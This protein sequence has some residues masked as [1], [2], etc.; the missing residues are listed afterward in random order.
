MKIRRQDLISPN[1]GN[2]ERMS[3]VNLS[4]P[5]LWKRIVWQTLSKEPLMISLA[6]DSCKSGCGYTSEMYFNLARLL[7]S[8]GAFKE[9]E[10]VDVCKVEVVFDCLTESTAVALL[11]ME[12]DVN[13]RQ[14]L[15]L[16]WLSEIKRTVDLRNSSDSPVL[17]GIFKQS[18]Q[19]FTLDAQLLFEFKQV[20][21]PWNE[22]V[23]DEDL[24]GLVVLQTTV[25]GLQD[26][27]LS[28]QPRQPDILNNV[29]KNIAHDLTGD[30]ELGVEGSVGVVLVP[31]WVQVGDNGRQSDGTVF[32][33][34]GRWVLGFKLVDTV[35]VGVDGLDEVL[36]DLHVEQVQDGF[37][38]DRG[39]LSDDLLTEMLVD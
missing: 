16:K 30:G 31:Q 4:T 10:E 20:L 14:E 29:D 13:R 22:L 28:W 1:K 39:Q 34:W 19:D 18:V 6:E 24:T 15:G 21:L 37:F 12:A 32:E 17:T 25:N 9:L 5:L 8:K 27:L 11:S 23:K 3:Y 2:P 36:V 38:L 26:N 7:I 35:V 33:S